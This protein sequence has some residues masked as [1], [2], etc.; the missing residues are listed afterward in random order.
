MSDI[1]LTRTLL[2]NIG[3]EWMSVRLGMKGSH[4]GA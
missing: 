1:M 4:S 2:L 3:L